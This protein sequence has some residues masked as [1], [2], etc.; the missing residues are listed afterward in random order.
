MEDLVKGATLLEPTSE[1][2]IEAAERRIGKRFDDEIR[3]LYAL[4][5]GILFNPGKEHYQLLPLHEVARARVLL[6]GTDSDD[7]GRE[8]FIGL[9]RIVDGVHVGFSLLDSR[10][11]YQMLEFYAPDLPEGQCP[12]VAA[13]AFEFV[14]NMNAAQ[15]RL[16]WL[17][18]D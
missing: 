8:E 3:S 4:S 16:Y 11:R 18:S 10:D 6:F 14:R 17:L 1:A 7:Y 2:E 12:V 9:L 13:S 5:N 15:G